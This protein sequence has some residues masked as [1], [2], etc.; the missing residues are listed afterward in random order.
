MSRK[1]RHRHAAVSTG[2][3]QRPA[4]VACARAQAVCPPA[5]RAARRLRSS[6]VGDVLRRCQGLHALDKINL[7]QAHLSAH[8]L[9]QEGG[10]L[11]VGITLRAPAVLPGVPEQMAMQPRP[12]SLDLSSESG[13]A[14]NPPWARSLDPAQPPASRARPAA[15]GEPAA[16][17]PTRRPLQRRTPPA[18]PCIQPIALPT[19]GGG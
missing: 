15:T 17:A 2:L 7:A 1:I 8:A 5:W 3:W 10:V 4:L 18:A 11:G 13:G 6:P 9:L 14:A 19:N 16:G 12:C